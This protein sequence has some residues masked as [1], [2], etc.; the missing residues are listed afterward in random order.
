MIDVLGKSRW[1]EERPL[2]I[3]PIEPNESNFTASF[4]LRPLH[5]FADRREGSL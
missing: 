5:G 3:Y 2:V 4:M 1:I